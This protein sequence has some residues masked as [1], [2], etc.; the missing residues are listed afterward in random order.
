MAKNEIQ[1][2]GGTQSGTVNVVEPSAGDDLLVKRL[3]EAWGVL[4][5]ATRKDLVA[6]AEAAALQQ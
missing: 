1:C 4:T 5:L 6:A 2:D 3:L